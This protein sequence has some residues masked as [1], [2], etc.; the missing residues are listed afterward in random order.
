MIKINARSP[1]YLEADIGD[2][3]PP[4]SPTKTIQVQCGDTYNTGIDVGN[5][6]YEVSTSETGT[7]TIDVTGNDV[8]VKFIVE[9]DGVEQVNTGFIGFDQY[10]QELLLAGVQQSE[11]NTG[12]PSNKTTT[13]TFNKTSVTPELVT[14]KAIAPLANDDYSLVFNCPQPQAVVIERNTEINIWFDSSGSM[15]STLSPLQS[16]V[17]NNLKDCLVQYYDNDPDRYDTYVRTRN[18]SDERTFKIAAT[19]PT[20]AGATNVINLIFQDEAKV[21]Y[22]YSTFDAG[23]RKPTYDSDITNLRN[24]LSSNP[25]EYITPIIFQVEFYESAFKDM[26]QA[27]ENDYGQYSGSF[28]LKDFNQQVKFYYDLEDGKSYS[29][30]PNYYRDY[31]I[32]AIND[33]GFSI[34]CP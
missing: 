13:L 26:M 23:F 10:D 4:T 15:V 12:D 7:M 22:H 2:I 21:V 8:P 34:V 18:F 29:T 31:I 11:I 20:I 19:L 32:Q 28:G 33:L 17:E 24:V 30:H 3:P 9:W 5:T 1:F 6:I 25:I 16:M 14:V 27:V